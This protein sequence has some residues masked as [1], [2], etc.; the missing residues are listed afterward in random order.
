MFWVSLD[1]FEYSSSRYLSSTER[2][3]ISCIGRNPTRIKN[4]IEEANRRYG[5]RT[6][7]KTS[8]Y[9]PRSSHRSMYMNDMR[10]VPCTAKPQRPLSSVI[11]DERQKDSFVS[12]VQGY[13]R[14][15]T[16]RW[17]SDRGIPYRRGYLFYGPPG[18]GKTS[19]CVAVA[20]HLGLSVYLLNLNSN[21]VDD[22]SLEI[23]FDLL[24]KRCVI[25]L[26]DVDTA[27]VAR[28]RDNGNAV[29]DS[30]TGESAPA[31]KRVS[32]SS[33]LNVIDGVAANEGRILIMT[34]NYV[35]KLDPALKRPGRIDMCVK[36][37]YCDK[38]ALRNLF[39]SMY[40][41]VGHGN[42]K[43]DSYSD[44]DSSENPVADEKK[45]HKRMVEIA[46]DE[47]ASLVPEGET[48]PASVQGYL[49]RYKNDPKAAVE[50]VR[51]W[52]AGLRAV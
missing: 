6:K 36:F 27:T 20:G 7:S 51:E 33:L 8:I 34:T 35:E 19:L 12:D 26:E 42:G 46:A 10:W 40:R 48:T 45:D 23:L 16:I 15:S 2:L 49:L 31:D 38:D 39:D 18:T 47:F 37:G 9:R 3:S 29:V 43:D 25:L 17:Y 30:E 4:I 22:D 1:G 11:L 13:M 44:I 52:V 28:T 5:E 41:D 21:N 32:L 24:P 14:P 50:G